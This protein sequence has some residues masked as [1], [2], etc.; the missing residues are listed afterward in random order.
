M[1][2]ATI[3]AIVEHETVTYSR[4]D[5]FGTIICGHCFAKHLEQN[6]GLL[7]N[8]PKDF[9][10]IMS[11][12]VLGMPNNDIILGRCF[13]GMDKEMS[14]S[15]HEQEITAELLIL[16]LIDENIDASPIQFIGGLLIEGDDGDCEYE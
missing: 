12:N 6:E 10:M 11:D 14:F 7:D 5:I 15:Q 1:R 3:K 9:V 13:Y 2:T 4:M 16:G 8:L